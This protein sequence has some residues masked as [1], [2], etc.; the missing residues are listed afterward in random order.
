MPIGRDAA[1][2]SN[3]AGSPPVLPPPIETIAELQQ[4][5]RAAEARAARMRLLSQ[6]G[7]ALAEAGPHTVDQVLQSCADRL[8][9]FLG[10]TSAEMRR[11][12]SDAGLAIKM[13]GSGERAFGTIV[14]ARVSELADIADP[15]DREAVRLQLELMGLTADRIE[16]EQDRSRLVAALQEREQRLEYVIDCLFSAQEEERRRVS[17]EL[18]DGVAQTAT[19][20]VRMIEVSGGAGAAPLADIARGLVQEL[21]GVIGNLRPPLLDDLGLEAA[22]RAMVD[23]LIADGF[24]VDLSIALAGARWAPMIETAIFRIAQEAISNIRKHAGG[25]CRVEVMLTSGRNGSPHRLTVRDHGRGC[26]RP[27]DARKAE[28]GAEVGIDVM[29][30]RMAALGGELRWDAAPTRGVTVTALI[31]AEGR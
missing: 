26:R 19:A 31:P 20:L 1:T 18:H 2:Q 29:R 28:R 21:R 6:T 23:D 15:E 3:M 30:E 11:D 16:R 13:P 12:G 27:A 25:P 7:R 4:L 8:A 5:Y 17:H 22:I 14:V 24:P 10:E 9:H